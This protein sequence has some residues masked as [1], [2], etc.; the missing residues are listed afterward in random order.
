MIAGPAILRL[1][2]VAMA[3][4]VAMRTNAAVESPLEQRQAVATEAENAYRRGV[5]A[6]N[7]SSLAEKAFRESAEGWR[8]VID[9][10]GDGPSSWF[11]LGNALLRAGEVGEAIVAYRTAQRLEPGADDVAANLAEARRRVERP[12]GADA[13]DLSFTD[14]A[15]WWHLLGP[16]TRLSLGVAGWISFWVLLFLRRGTDESHRHAERESITAAW[17]GG[18]TL[19]LAIALVG[20]LTVVADRAFARWRPVGVVTAESATLRSG[21]GEAF[22]NLTTEPLTEGIEFAIEET[23]PGWWRVRLPDDTVGW[24]STEDAS[25]VG[26]TDIVNP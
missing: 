14:V 16:R 3:L 24:I 26:A 12:I 22:E 7:G 23:R 17:R 10:G 2:F 25:A 21:N 8:T 1:A 18:L 5:E 20:G 19:S 6:A 9:L 4:S 13:N 15:S 11:N